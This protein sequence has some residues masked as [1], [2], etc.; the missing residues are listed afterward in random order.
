MGRDFSGRPPRLQT[1]RCLCYDD[2]FMQTTFGNERAGAGL[3]KQVITP[4]EHCDSVHIPRQWFGRRVEVLIFPLPAD[5]ET[6]P[7]AAKPFRVNRRRLES[8]RAPSSPEFLSDNL[9]RADRDAR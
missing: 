2:G 3:F 8:M 1:R 5:T 4:G 6:A 9:I 7:P